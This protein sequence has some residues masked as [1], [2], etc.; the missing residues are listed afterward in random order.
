MQAAQNPDVKKGLVNFDKGVV[1]P[2]W[3][4]HQEWI[5]R[6]VAGDDR[7]TLLLRSTSKLRRK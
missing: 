2:H 6:L 7:L 4:H 5:P 3:L 1:G